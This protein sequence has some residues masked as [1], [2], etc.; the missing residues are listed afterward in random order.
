M[1]AFTFCALMLLA[2]LLGQAA[3]ARHFARRN[4][5]RRLRA[6]GRTLPVDHAE[7]VITR[8]ARRTRAS[9]AGGAA[10]VVLITVVL[11]VVDPTPE[12][13]PDLSRVALLLSGLALGG[14]GAEALHILRT[15]PSSSAGV[16]VASLSA[17]E[18]HLSDREARAEKALIALAVVL[19]PVS[20][21]AW[22]IDQ[23]T[24]AAIVC[25]GA[26]VTTM[27]IASLT[28]RWLL[29]RPAPARDADDAVGLEL[30]TTL[31]ADRF[32]EG[33]VAYGSVLLLYA[34][35][36]TG[37][38]ALGA[39]IWIMVLTVGV[40]ATLTAA[41]ERSRARKEVAA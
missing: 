8:I 19:L 38:H 5:A 39:F 4:A 29:D 32:T 35:I 21:V 40:W 1:I 12:G 9:A 17:R 2:V 16:R 24:A 20:A 10:A 31:S 37:V 18:P 25:L 23:G 6:A 28:R 13:A 27:L 11:W 3:T 36:V 41:T 30:T 26:A 14:T 22:L 34:A 7:V 15:T 33:L